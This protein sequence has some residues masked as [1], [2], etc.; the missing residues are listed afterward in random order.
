MFSQ[1]SLPCR[2]SCSQG[3]TW[4]FPSRQDQETGE[5]QREETRRTPPQARPRG[6]LQRAL[7]VWVTAEKS[8]APWAMADHSRKL[9]RKACQAL[10]GCGPKSAD[11]KGREAGGGQ[12][13]PEHEQ[14]ALRRGAA[15]GRNRWHGRVHANTLTSPP[16]FWKKSINSPSRPALAGGQHP[17]VLAGAARIVESRA[18]GSPAVAS[19]PAGRSRCRTPRTGS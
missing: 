7:V 5:G 15:A 9:M 10:C 13:R 18:P 11:E 6:P 12:H 17:E 8:T 1:T 2:S 16:C 4:S 3:N 14:G 19:R